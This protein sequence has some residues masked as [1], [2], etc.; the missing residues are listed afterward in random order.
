MA[1]IKLVW[2]NKNESHEYGNGVAGDLCG[3]V[4]LSESLAARRA[5]LASS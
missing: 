3:N 1:K 2:W 5:I 4:A